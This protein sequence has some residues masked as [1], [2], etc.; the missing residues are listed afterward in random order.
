M[1]C[2]LGLT[3]CTY[4]DMMDKL[5]PEEESK[6]AEEYLEKLRERDFEYVKD[7]LSDEIRSQVTDELLVKMADYFRSGELVSTEIIG[8]QVHV[9]NGVW[10]GNFS[11][12]YHFSNGWNLGNAVLR[13]IDGKYEVIGINVYQTEMSQKEIHAFNLS[14]KS[15]LHYIILVLAVLVP[16]FIIVSTVVCI[17]TPIP[18]RK[19]L[20]VVFVLLG[21]SA[22]QINWT[23]GQYAIQ[24]VNVNLL[25]SAAASISPHAAWVISASIPLGA[26]MFWFKRKKFLELSIEANDTP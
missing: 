8:S 12:E 20:W 4:Q 17:R 19:W 2:V 21:V 16:I 23:T 14:N 13:K 11:F 25:G 5:I 24:L 10:Q 6:W 15:I 26:I 18:K 22:I 9:F 3:S 1:V 7:K